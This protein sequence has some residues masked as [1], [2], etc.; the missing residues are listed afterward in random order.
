LDI[1]I[2]KSVQEAVDFLAQDGLTRVLAGGTDI[3]VQFNGHATPD[4]LTLVSIGEIPELKQITDNGSEIVIGAMV[5]D[6]QIVDSDSIKKEAY[7]VWWAAHESAGPQ[8]RNRATVGGNI[9]T[10]SPAADVLCALEALDAVATVVGP[11]GSRQVPVCEIP[12][13]VK[14]NSLTKGE[15][16]TT[17][18]IPKGWTSGFQKQG[19]RKAMT[20]SA[21]NAAAAVKMNGDIIE[22]V[23]VVIGS[24]NITHVRGVELENALK[25]KSVA[26]DKIPSIA[27]SVSYSIAPISDAR[28]PAWYR[29]E[30]VPVL[31]G[32]AVIAACEGGEQG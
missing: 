7:A 26:L 2:A 25:G 11:K 3:L 23:R 8:V 21:I 28:A 16:I 30:L 15:L 20:I 4:D 24:A 18:S 5:T 9:G 19:K 17:I 22:D 14:Q 31:A 1:K 13:G 32:R 27:K 12:C 29:K 10:S 6:S